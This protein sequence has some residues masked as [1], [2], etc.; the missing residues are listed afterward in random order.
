MGFLDDLKREAEEK[1]TNE[2]ATLHTKQE[3]ER[4]FHDVID[5]VMRR[6]FSYSQELAKNLNYVKPDVQPRYTIP[7]VSVEHAFKQ[8]EYFVD[9]YHEGRFSFRFMCES[10]HKYNVKANSEADL[11]RMKDFLWRNGLRYQSREFF[12]SAYSKRAEF[13]IEGRV[14]VEIQ[15]AARP[16]TT[17][18]DV[19]ITN[20]DGFGKTQIS[21][22]PE[23]I[24]DEFNDQLAHFVVRKANRLLEYNR[25]KFTDEQ[26][27]ELQSQLGN[28]SVSAA[29]A[30]AVRSAPE[31]GPAKAPDKKGGSLLGGLFRRR[32]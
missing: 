25:Y 20:Y 11:D 27:R 8:S 29:P 30:T 12:D 7:G 13:Y 26:R 24:D 4:V 18:I 16:D 1:M 19:V 22:L 6:L 32:K 2:E 15:F 31:T 14:P 21:I 5:P 23:D 28:G 9:D 17:S 3:Q 10:G